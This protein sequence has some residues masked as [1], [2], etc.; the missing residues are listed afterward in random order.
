MRSSVTKPDG[1]DIRLILE[2]IYF[3]QRDNPTDPPTYGAI[4][5]K[6]PKFTKYG[7]HELRECIMATSHLVPDLIVCD[8]HKVELNASPEAIIADI[9][10]ELDKIKDVQEDG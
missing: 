5:F 3:I 2:I 7:E 10:H 1:P 4:K 9:K 8:M 6:E